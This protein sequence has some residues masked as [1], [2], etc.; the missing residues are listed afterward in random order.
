M[1]SQRQHKKTMSALAYMWKCLTRYCTH[2]FTDNIPQVNESSHDYLENMYSA[3]LFVI[4]R[5]AYWMWKD[6]I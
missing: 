6:A 5:E 1:G 2:V 3:G 4:C